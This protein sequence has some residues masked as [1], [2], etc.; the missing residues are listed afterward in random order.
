MADGMQGATPAG[1]VVATDVSMR[2]GT[3]KS[4]E[5]GT[6]WQHF[7]LSGDALRDTSCH[8]R[9][10]RLIGRAAVICRPSLEYP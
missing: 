6:P 8:K 3:T 1:G 9:G 4:D 10:A 2:A 5:F 7:R